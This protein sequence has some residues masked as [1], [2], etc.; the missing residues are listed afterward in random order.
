MR[1]KIYYQ[2][3]GKLKIKYL[4]A[5]NKEELKTLKE[6]PTNIIDIKQRGSLEKI[7]IDTRFLKNRKKLVL[8]VFKQLQIMLEAN[9]TFNSSLKLLL[10]NKQDPVI[11]NIIKDME[12]S[13]QKSK[14]IDEVLKRYNS[15]LDNTTLLFL[16]LGIE[17]GNIKDAVSSIVELLEQD[18][19]TKERLKESFRYP[20]ILLVSLAIAFCMIF[21][22]VIPNFESIFKSFGDDLPFSTKLLMNFGKFMEQK[23]YMFIGF[24]SVFIMLFYIFYKKHKRFFHMILILKVPILKSVIQSY[25]YHKLFLSIYIIVRSKYQ[26]QIA[27]E[28]SFSMVG[29][30]FLKEKIKGVVSDIKKGTSIAKAFEKSGLFDNIT[31]QLL[32]TAQHSNSYE[33]ILNDITKMYKKRFEDSIKDFSSF[34]NPFIILLIA[35]LILWVVLGI[36][37]PTWSI[38]QIM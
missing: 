7:K 20:F 29:N 28:H 14:P 13:V 16:K 27:V 21:I 34:I 24:I 33:L 12:S 6:Y 37:T 36:M 38:S 3:K 11:Y 22:F 4:E 5:Q 15:Y 19:K 18:I 25:L 2:Q 31:I 32:Y 23:W 8:G 9:L 10:E 30:I 1:Y 35:L 26:F 17:R